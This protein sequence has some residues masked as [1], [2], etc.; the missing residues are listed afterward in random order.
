MG[1]HARV[2]VLLYHSVRN[3]PTPGYEHWETSLEQLRTQLDQLAAL[4]REVVSLDTYARWLRDPGVALPLRPVVITFDDGFANVL[5]VVPLLLER[6]CPITLFVPTAYVGGESDWLEPRFRRR[7]LTWSQIVDLDRSGIEIGSHAHMHRPIDTLRGAELR[8]D[9]AQSR[10][11]IE[12]R[13]GHACASFAYPHGYSSHAVRR[14]VENAGF[15]QACAV[16]D[17]MSGQG[18]DPMAVARLFVGWDDVGDRFDRLFL[19]GRRR[20]R[21]ERLVTRGWRIARRV[22]ARGSAM[23][24]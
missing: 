18:D 2:P 6:A 8:A 20:A 11:L 14:V 4:G 21:H 22:H 5:D 7:M 17:A 13:L 9:V 19:V 16:N 12:D 15:T 1:N 10:R 3:E 24:A 23:S